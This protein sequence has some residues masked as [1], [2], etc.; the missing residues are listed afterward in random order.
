MST[1]F[2]FNFT[3]V[4]DSEAESLQR[5]GGA[6]QGETGVESLLVGPNATKAK[7][8]MLT[9]S[10]EEADKGEK[11]SGTSVPSFTC[12]SVIAHLSQPFRPDGI[13]SSH[14]LP[15][16]AYLHCIGLLISHWYITSVF[17]IGIP[18]RHL[19]SGVP[20]VSHIASDILGLGPSDIKEEAMKQAEATAAKQ[21]KG[22]EKGKTAE[23]KDNPMGEKDA[24]GEEEEVIG[25]E[26]E[27]LV[28]HPKAWM[29][30]PSKTEKNHSKCAQCKRVQVACFGKPGHACDGCHKF[31]VC[32]G[33]SM[34]RTGPAENAKLA[35][36]TSS[37]TESVPTSCATKPIMDLICRAA[38]DQVPVKS[39]DVSDGEEEAS[40][41]KNPIQARP[42]PMTQGSK[43]FMKASEEVDPS[44]GESSS[45]A[46]DEVNVQMRIEMSQLEGRFTQV[47]GLMIELAQGMNFICTCM[48]RKR[49]MCK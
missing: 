12:R 16:S 24:E 31:K 38:S 47:Q 33:F 13:E 28:M 5:Q 35:W 22:K 40:T 39:M 6:V 44:D 20:S 27:K 9:L 3:S 18:H 4:I 36:K 15:M 23:P 7:G 8:L 21:A 43:K 17:F 49:K 1:P 14:V 29:S 19:A 42:V 26:K 34:A 46:E 25:K 10:P 32:C 2:A 11:E 37:A 48:E 45:S 41:P 30:K